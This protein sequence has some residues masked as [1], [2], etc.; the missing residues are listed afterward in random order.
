MKKLKRHIQFDP[1]AFWKR[2]GIEG[3]NLKEKL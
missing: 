3:A 1:K 2:L